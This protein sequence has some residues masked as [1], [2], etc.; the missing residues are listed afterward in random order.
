MLHWYMYV[1][2]PLTVTVSS[3]V[4]STEPAL[5]SA[6]QVYLPLE[7]IVGLVI[8]S[9]FQTPSLINL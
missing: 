2:I 3:A 9:L 4:H 5:F 7:S 8:T 6:L 1:T